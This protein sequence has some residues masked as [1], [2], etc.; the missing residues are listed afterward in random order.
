VGHPATGGGDR[1]KKAREIVITTEVV[2]DGM[3]T[4]PQLTDERRA[5]LSDQTRLGIGFSR[6]IPADQHET[7]DRGSVYSEP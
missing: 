5:F 1:A 2:A 7:K 3:P 4:H 6:D